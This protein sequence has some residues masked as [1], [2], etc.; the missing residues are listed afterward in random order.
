MAEIEFGIPGATPYSY[1]HIKTTTEELVSQPIE[2]E[3]LGRTHALLM[4]A[5]K[6]GE[7][8]GRK[9]SAKPSTAPSGPA[10]GP[11]MAD[12]L[13]QEEVGS[14]KAAAQRLDS[15]Q[16]PRTVGEANEM[17][18]ELIKR[19]LGGT[20]VEEYKVGDTVTVAGVEFT[21]HSDVP[22]AQEK[23]EAA[24][25]AAKPKPWEKSTAQRVV[26]DLL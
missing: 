11:S 20:V 24:V 22:Y 26:E 17:A 8:E 6:A 21:K 14:P 4:A 10:S 25:K 16:K 13:R 12:L 5:F 9:L 7:A 1:V 2:A 18:S 23:V 15:D 19:E 3:F